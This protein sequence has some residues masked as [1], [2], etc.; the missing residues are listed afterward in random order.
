[1]SAFPRFGLLCGEDNAVVQYKSDNLDLLGSIDPT[2]FDELAHLVGIPADHD[3]QEPVRNAPS[4][5]TERRVRMA[6]VLAVCILGPATR[7][8]GLRSRPTQCDNFF[9]R[10]SR[11]PR[12]PAFH[13]LTELVGRCT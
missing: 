3:S 2:F 5:D 1:V 4:A 13:G 8:D 7:Y 12:F 10:V 9:V 11:S 6:T